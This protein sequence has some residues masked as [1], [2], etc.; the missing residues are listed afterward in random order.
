ME[1]KYVF[2]GSDRVIPALAGQVLV[3]DA[4][5]AAGLGTFVSSS[6]FDEGARQLI[7]PLQTMVDQIL[8]CSICQRWLSHYTGDRYRRLA[9][10]LVVGDWQVLR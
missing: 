2:Q 7:C 8:E 3:L 6:F 4:F 1:I 9:Q 10:G 5:S